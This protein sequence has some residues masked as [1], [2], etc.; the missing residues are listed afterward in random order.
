M[1]HF[2]RLRAPYPSINKDLT[3]F[4]SNFD[5]HSV[6]LTFQANYFIELDKTLLKFNHFILLVFFNKNICFLF[7]IVISLWLDV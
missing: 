3:F 5:F 1:V 2:Q 4:F 7:I 6:P